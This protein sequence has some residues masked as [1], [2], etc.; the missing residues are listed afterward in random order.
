M[1]TKQILAREEQLVKGLIPLQHTLRGLQDYLMGGIPVEPPRTKP[2]PSGGF[3]GEIEALQ[4][5]A[6]GELNQAQA[7]VDALVEAINP[8]EVPTA[9]PTGTG[10][11]KDRLIDKTDDW[12]RRKDTERFNKAAAQLD[13]EIKF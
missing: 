11:Y 13:K 1:A 9:S 8:T 4:V 3:F 5:D 10:L 6:Y 2:G 7:L 12:E